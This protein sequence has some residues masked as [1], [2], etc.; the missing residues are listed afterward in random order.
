M[1]QIK[2]A[3]LPKNQLAMK[4]VPGRHEGKDMFLSTLKG[5]H[6]LQLY[7]VTHSQLSQQ[8]HCL[9]TKLDYLSR[10]VFILNWDNLSLG[11]TVDK[12]GILV[13]LPLWR[14]A[15]VICVS[16]GK[17]KQVVMFGA[18]VFKKRYC[19]P[20]KKALHGIKNSQKVTMVLSSGSHRI[21]T[22]LQ[23]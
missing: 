11:K 17:Y 23:L 6:P 7:R 5:K 13:Q 10:A 16:S 18:D 19:I 2:C 4:A 1:S 15:N 12:E 3:F 22:F 14:R 20:R 21:K 9:R 8:S